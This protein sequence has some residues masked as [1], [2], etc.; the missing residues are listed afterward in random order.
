MQKFLKSSSQLPY[1]TVNSIPHFLLLPYTQDLAIPNRHIP[2]EQCDKLKLN[3]EYVTLMRQVRNMDVSL[4][5]LYLA[6]RCLHNSL[7]S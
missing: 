2:D 7:Y 6:I 5:G 4:A 3:L 1:S